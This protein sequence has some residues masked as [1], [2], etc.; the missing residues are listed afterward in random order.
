[1]KKFLIMV[2]VLAFATGAYGAFS[3][4]FDGFV[5]D[6]FLDGTPDDNGWH[7]W[8]GSP[9]AGAYVR[10]D[11]ALSMPYSVEI[12]G[13]TDLVQEYTGAT[14]GI[15]RYT[16]SQYIPNTAGGTTYF[17]LLNNFDDPTSTYAWS[18]QLNFD[19]NANI[20]ND[21]QAAGAENMPIIFDQW[22]SLVFDIDLDNNTV[23]TYYGG[24]F[25]S[26]HQWY[27]ANGMPPHQKAI[28]AVDLYANNADPVYYDNISLSQVPE[29]GMFIMA[30]LGLLG[31]FFRRK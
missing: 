2:V 21:D 20:L 24:A 22:V 27:D 30:G 15:W 31:L 17:I 11:Q 6:Q 28:E 1:M 19:T 16:A 14:S 12:A 23:D 26:T 7:G 5:N 4:N 3:E 10:D 13:G 9:A 25:L 8:G 29:P 18:V